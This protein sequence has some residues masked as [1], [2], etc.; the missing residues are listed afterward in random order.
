MYTAVGN[1]PRGPRSQSLIN[2]RSISESI[3]SWGLLK[4]MVLLP[5]G[6]GQK[7]TDLFCVL[8][9]VM[10]GAHLY[11]DWSLSVLYTAVGQSPEKKII[12]T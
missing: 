4:Q 9:N 12:F 5:S 6:A 8:P 11:V 7:P 1:W 10:Y 3:S 2:D